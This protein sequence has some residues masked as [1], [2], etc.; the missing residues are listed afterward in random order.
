MTFAIDANIL[1]Y[2]ADDSSQFQPAAARFFER[3]A[4][5]P[6]LAYVFWPSVMAYLRVT[7]RSTIFRHPLTQA[8]ALEN[9]DRL[10]A[11]PSVVSTGER[12]QFWQHFRDVHAD[13]MP[14][15][16]LVSD[17][18]LVALMLENGVRTIW[19]HDRDFRRFPS[20]RVRDPIE[21]M[22]AP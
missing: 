17:A 7:T 2:A 10:L 12:E 21:E 18:H 14:T 13:A 20:I 1:I 5:G 19:S 6:E 15:G 11:L 9:I 22:E 3:V 4:D 8:R 16:N